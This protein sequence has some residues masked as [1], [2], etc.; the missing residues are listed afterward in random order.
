MPATTRRPG[1]IGRLVEPHGSLN[2][3]LDAL[4]ARYAAQAARRA[5]V[6]RRAAP[7]KQPPPRPAPHV[8]DAQVAD[9]CRQ[10]EANL[11]RKKELEDALGPALG[12]AAYKNHLAMSRPKKPVILT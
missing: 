9:L 1:R 11:R 7:A 8:S 4:N 6:T 5:T 2:D 10:R 3:V 12:G